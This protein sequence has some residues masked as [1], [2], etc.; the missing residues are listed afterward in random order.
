MKLLLYGWVGIKKAG[1]RNLQ[2]IYSVFAHVPLHIY[3]VR[4]NASNAKKA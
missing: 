1:F 4:Y 3:M 2:L